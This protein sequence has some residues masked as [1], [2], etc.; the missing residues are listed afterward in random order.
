MFDHKTG[1]FEGFTKAYNVH[2]LVYFERFSS[3]QA[4]I[5]REK[6]LKG[7]R[8]AKKDALVARVNPGWK[9]LSEEWY[10]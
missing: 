10:Q 6:Q 1:R 2:R 3:V 4:A 9:D 8:R 5:A 7:W